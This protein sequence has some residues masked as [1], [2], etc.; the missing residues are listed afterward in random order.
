MKI[1]DLLTI[2]TLITV[3]I[4]PPIS[5][6][7]IRSPQY[8]DDVVDDYADGRIE[9]HQ[10]LTEESLAGDDPIDQ[11]SLGGDDVYDRVPMPLGQGM[12][13]PNRVI[14]AAP[15]LPIGGALMNIMGIGGGGMRPPTGY[16]GGHRRGRPPISGSKG[17]VEQLTEEERKIKS[18]AESNPASNS[19][20]FD[21]N[22]A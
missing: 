1:Q 16:G 3:V 11:D 12:M 21:R 14:P 5:N 17:P 20:V 7:R 19:P 2:T 6:T 9:Q 15:L 13:G 18:S 22:Q 8:Y 4:V 10:A